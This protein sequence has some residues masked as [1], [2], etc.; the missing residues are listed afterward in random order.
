[1][2][3]TPA[4]ATIVQYHPVILGSIGGAILTVIIISVCITC[5]QRHKEQI[6]RMQ[7]L[8]QEQRTTVEIEMTNLLRRSPQNSPYHQSKNDHGAKVNHVGNAV[9]G[10]VANHKGTK[11]HRHL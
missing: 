6:R 1:V 4:P 5:H 9:G 2:V 7:A 8:K 10:S 3:T 11:L